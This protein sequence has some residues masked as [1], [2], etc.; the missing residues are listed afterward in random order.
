MITPTYKQLERMAKAKGYAWF[1]APYDLNFIGIRSNAKHDDTFNDTI[2]VAYKD[3]DGNERV[4]CA[5]FTCDPGIYYLRNPMNARGT[6]I[7]PEGQYRSFWMLGKHKGYVALVQ[8]KAIRVLRDN[9]KNDLLGGTL[10]VHPELGGFNF[11]RA[12]ENSITKTIGKFTSGCQVVQVPE[13]FN[14][15][16]SLVKLQV[17]YV[18]SAFISYTLINEKEL[19]KW[20]N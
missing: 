20:D 10:S 5:P 17:R 12:L 13:D 6:A 2:A 19:H 9:D 15:I 14:Y 1:T 8:R 4:F 3:A 18:K 16:I 11:H 7:I